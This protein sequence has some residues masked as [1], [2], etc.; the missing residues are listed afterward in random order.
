MACAPRAARACSARGGRALSEGARA[1]VARA[2][3]MGF[4]P[5]REGRVELDRRFLEDLAGLLRRGGVASRATASL[6]RAM[7]E[8]VN[9]VELIDALRATVE[10]VDASPHPEGA[11]APAR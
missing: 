7:Q 2:Q 5:V 9:E 8:P 4:L 3:T 10:A 6:A 11:W 1:L